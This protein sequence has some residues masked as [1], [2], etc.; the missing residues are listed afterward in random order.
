MQTLI[1]RLAS[2]AILV[3]DGAMGSLLQAEGLPPGAPP[4]SWCLLRP[5]LVRSVAE[6]YL[7]AGSDMV[8]TNSFGGS[9]LKLA[10]HG[11]ASST[12]S[13]WGSRPSASR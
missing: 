2:G 5:E 10:R 1:E 3:S 6:R 4:E 9:P 13:R 12:R 11:L 8:L 7:A